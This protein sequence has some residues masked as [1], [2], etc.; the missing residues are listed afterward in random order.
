MLIMRCLRRPRKWH[1]LHQWHKP[2]TSDHWYEIDHCCWIPWVGLYLEATNLRDWVFG[3]EH[4]LNHLQIVCI[5]PT[6]LATAASILALHIC[7]VPFSQVPVFLVG[8]PHL[9]QEA[10]GHENFKAVRWVCQQKWL[11]QPK[12]QETQRSWSLKKHYIQYY[13]ILPIYARL[14]WKHNIEIHRETKS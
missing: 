1:R 14:I 9:A 7:S 13:S 5:H 6:N 11:S 12:V 4:E 3:S 10:R 2:L 8:H